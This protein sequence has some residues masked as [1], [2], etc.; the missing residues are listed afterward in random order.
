[1]DKFTSKSEEKERKETGI[2]MV[3]HFPTSFSVRMD[4]L[5]A[6]LLGQPTERCPHGCSESEEKLLVRGVWLRGV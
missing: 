6:K 5:I 4:E 2:D 1:M 3:V